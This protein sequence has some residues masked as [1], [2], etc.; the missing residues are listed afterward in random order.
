MDHGLRC[1]RCGTSL[2]ALSLP[3]LR[4][5]ECPSCRA[6]LHVCRMCGHFD[7][8]L[9]RQCRE[10]GPEEV[11]KKDAANFCDWFRPSPTAFDAAGAVADAAARSAADALFGGGAPR[12]A[13][14]DPA[15]QAADALFGSPR[16]PDRKH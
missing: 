7:K 3:L 5:E 6:E 10:E 9:Q 12:A 16:P 13:A 1:W 8:R 15:A 4:R 11:R 14:A 2:A